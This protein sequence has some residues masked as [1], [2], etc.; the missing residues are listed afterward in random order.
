MKERILSTVVGTIQCP[1]TALHNEVT[2]LVVARQNGEPIDEQRYEQTIQTAISRIVRAEIEIGL[3]G[4]SDGGGDQTSFMDYVGDGRLAGVRRSS[5]GGNWVPP[6]L[7]R[8][9]EMIEMAYATNTPHFTGIELTGPVVYHNLTP[10]QRAIAR[11]RTALAPHKDTYTYAF[12]CSLSPGVLAD[13]LWSWERPN[14]YY[15]TYSDL[16]QAC[17]QAMAEEYR[18]I[19]RAGFVLQVDAPDLLMSG[20]N[21]LPHGLVDDYRQQLG[22]RIG[23]ITLALSGLDEERIRIHVCSGNWPGTHECDTSLG[24]A[25]DL[26]LQLPGALSIEGANPTHEDEWADLQSI[27]WPAGKSLLYGVVDTKYPHYE[28]ARLVA[29]RLIRVAEI[30]GPEHVWACTD[31]GFNTFVGRRIFTPEMSW[32]KIRREVEGARLASQRLWQTVRE[33]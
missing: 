10:L 32:E 18:E 19:A 17:A 5:Q 28:T 26:L 13:Q 4:I 29:Q 33:S 27:K 11:F 12:L 8:H 20:Q 23:A 14:P 9:P 6:D 25:L 30:I 16:L 1:E 2:R 31:C 24:Q 15:A 22:W 21:L 7:E 3:D